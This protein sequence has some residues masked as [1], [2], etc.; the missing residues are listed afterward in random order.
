MQVISNK[1]QIKKLRFLDLDGQGDDAQEIEK[2][3]GRP[4]SFRCSAKG[5]MEL[6]PEKQGEL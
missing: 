2:C 4:N 1:R 6:M 3:K 5:S